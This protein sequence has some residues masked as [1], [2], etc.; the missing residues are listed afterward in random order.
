VKV[1]NSLFIKKLHKG[2]FVVDH[3]GESDVKGINQNPLEGIL[4]YGDQ[5]NAAHD[6]AIF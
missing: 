5:Y 6:F 3:S 4:E 1:K 2:D